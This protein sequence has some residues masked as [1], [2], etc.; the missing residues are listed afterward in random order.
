M[1]KLSA[2]V[3]LGLGGV[4]YAGPPQPVTTPPTDADLQIAYSL[5]TKRYINHDKSIDAK[6]QPGYEICDGIVSMWEVRQKAWSVP[7]QHK[8]KIGAMVGKK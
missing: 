7:E 5:C 3:L 2:I 4:A 1:I 8:S 6:W